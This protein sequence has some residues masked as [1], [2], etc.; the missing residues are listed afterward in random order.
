MAKPHEPF[1]FDPESIPRFDL[2][3]K[4]DEPS[5]PGSAPLA[6][7]S[8]TA[9][10]V[11]PEPAL[12]TAGSPAPQLAR[13][14]AAIELDKLDLAFDP[15]RSTFEDPTPSVL[16]GQW[17]D[18][19]TKLDLAKAYQ[20]MGDV[21]GAREILQEVLHEGDDQQKTEAQGLL[22]KLA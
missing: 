2:D 3:F 20:E 1:S 22:S 9:H 19:A 14:A 18:A 7:A 4:L 5:K 13:P 16:D 8:A 15:Q 21:E 17:H 11:T 10:A 6:K 12:A